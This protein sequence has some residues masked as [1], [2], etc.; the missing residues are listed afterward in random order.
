[1]TSDPKRQNKNGTRLLKE[2]GFR[3]QQGKENF[4]FR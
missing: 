3:N 4:M 2:L 1:M